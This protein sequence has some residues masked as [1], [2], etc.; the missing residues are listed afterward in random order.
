MICSIKILQGWH[1][2]TPRY[3]RYAFHN[4]RMLQLLLQQTSNRSN[5]M[6]YL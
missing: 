2:T 1:P 4:F 6:H 5:F 3:Y